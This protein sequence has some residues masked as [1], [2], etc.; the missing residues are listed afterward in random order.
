MVEAEVQIP[1]GMGRLAIYLLLHLCNLS[2][3]L[4]GRDK[5]NETEE[6]KGEE[7]GEERFTFSAQYFFNALI[8]NTE[9]VGRTLES[10]RK[11]F[12]NAQQYM[13]MVA[14]RSSSQRIYNCCG[15]LPR[16]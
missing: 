14:E 3:C 9:K 7:G 6:E 1:V 11:T 15:F 10:L 8:D 12:A 2:P 16:T 5:Q 13:L 4:W